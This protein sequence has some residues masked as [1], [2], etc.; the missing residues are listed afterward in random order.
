MNRY[1]RQL[2]DKQL[3]DDKAIRNFI[4]EVADILDIFPY[5]DNMEDVLAEQFEKLV[6]T[7]PEVDYSED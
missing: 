4:I 3:P 7:F 2:I 6:A 5:T 1:T